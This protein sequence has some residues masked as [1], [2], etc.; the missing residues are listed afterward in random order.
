MTTRLLFATLLLATPAA[1]QSLIIDNEDSPPNFITTGNDWTDWGM[2]GNGFDSGDDDYLYLS[3]TLGGSD[4]R[5]TAIWSADIPE[6]GTYRIGTWFRR[7]SNRTPDADFIVM[8]GNGVER[9]FS[10]N[11]RGDG[12]SG[13]VNFGTFWCAAG[14]DGCR[15]T[16]DGNDDDHSDEANAVRF[17][18]V[19]GDDTPPP[20]EVEPESPPE[21]P[22]DCSLYAGLGDHRQRAWATTVRGDSDW[23]REGRATGRPDGRGA[24][25]PNL[26]SGEFLRARGWTVCD[27]LGEEVITSVRLSVRARTQYESGRYDIV[28]RLDGGGSAETLWRDTDYGWRTVDVTGDRATWTWADVAELRGQLTLHSHP[29]GRRDSD[30][31]VDAWRLRVDYTTTAPPT[32]PADEARD[33]GGEDE[34][35]ECE[36]GCDEESDWWW[37]DDGT[38][39]HDDDV[40]PD[41]EDELDG[42]AAEDDEPADL[43]DDELDHGGDDDAGADDDGD[44]DADA[45]G[46][47][48]EWGDS[49][50]TFGADPSPEPTGAGCASAT[51]L[52]TT[53]ALL[54]LALF[55]L[56]RRRDE[57]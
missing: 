27:P 41:D 17:R 13:W 26:D 30:L 2:L 16:L 28:V 34:P 21:P 4:R 56:R 51:E 14:R 46:S 43:S 55:G 48:P 9:S 45:D 1:A 50:A 10:I 18:R 35:D 3:H 33:D 25:T 22:A 32:M 54:P 53:T 19:G 40:A 12:A 57:V 7:T 29:N 36:G 44:A 11:Q 6:A 31:W 42:Y 49:S 24:H 38:G 52:Q 20:P 15:V 37:D 47:G 5:G 23:T 39:A 8:D